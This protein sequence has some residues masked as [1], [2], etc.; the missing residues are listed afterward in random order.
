MPNCL[1]EVSVACFIPISN[2]SSCCS[3]SLS[4]FD[5][6]SI[7]DFG[8]SNRCLLVSHCVWILNPLIIYDGFPGGTMVKNPLANAGDTRD[9]GSFSWGEKMPWSRK[10]QPTPV[11]LPGKF[12]GQRSLVDYSPWGHTVGHGWACISLLLL[13]TCDIEHIFI[14]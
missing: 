10:R 6:F 4:L 11:F 7:W 3:I 14:C 9:V 2:E 12:H 5:V 13:M 8:R 1:P